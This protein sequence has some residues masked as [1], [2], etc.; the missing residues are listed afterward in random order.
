[1]GDAAAVTAG[2]SM[3]VRPDEAVTGKRPFHRKNTTPVAAFRTANWVV[4]GV[5]QTAWNLGRR[6]LLVRLAKPKSLKSRGA[7]R[8]NG[9]WLIKKTR[10]PLSLRFGLRSRWG[11]RDGLCW[12]AERKP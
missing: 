9:A 7:S 5:L 1:M 6:V 12:C 2:D 4:F 10:F 11:R 3:R 8:G